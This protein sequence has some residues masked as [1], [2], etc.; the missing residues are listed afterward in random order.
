MVNLPEGLF[1][2]PNAIRHCTSSTSPCS[3]ARPTSQ[4]GIVTIRANYAGEPGQPARHRPGLRHRVPRAATRRPASPSSSPTLNIPISVPITVRTGSDYGLRMTR[5]RD[6]PA[7]PAG[8]RRHDRLGLPG[9]CRA[10]HRT[11]PARLTR[12]PGGLPGR[13][14]PRSARPNRQCAEDSP[15]PAARPTTRRSAPAAAD[16]H[17]LEVADLPGPAQ[18]LPR[19]GPAIRRRPTARN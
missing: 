13:R 19:R 14:R 12:Q 4:A 2:N 16:R 1:G 7:D 6:H 11:L 18:P 10:R 8:R 9:R 5:H 17:S 15:H 3:S